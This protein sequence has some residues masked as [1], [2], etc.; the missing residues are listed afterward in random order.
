V[1]AAATERRIETGTA[2]SVAPTNCRRRVRSQIVDRVRFE[3]MICRVTDL[4]VWEGRVE[5]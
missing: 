1:R 3:G 4:V 5:L 2:E